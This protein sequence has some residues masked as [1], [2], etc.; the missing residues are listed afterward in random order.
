MRDTLVYERRVT[1]D[2]TLESTKEVIA[3]M[4]TGAQLKFEWVDNKMT[5]KNAAR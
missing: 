5:F 4:E 2:A 3:A 1:L